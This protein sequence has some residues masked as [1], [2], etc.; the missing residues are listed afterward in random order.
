MGLADLRAKGV[1][2]PR[3]FW[4]PAFASGQTRALGAE[5]SRHVDV[6]RLKAGEPV[7]LFDGKGR[8]AVGSLVPCDGEWSVRVEEVRPVGMETASIVLL[9]GVPKSPKLEQLVRM[10]SEV[11]VAAIHLM[12]TERSVIRPR[13]DR[14]PRQLERLGKIASEAA[15]QSERSTVPRIYPPAPMSEVLERAPAESL[16]LVCV[17]G[18]PPLGHVQSGRPVWV[19]VGPE[20]GLSNQ[21]LRTMSAMEYHPVGLVGHVLRVETA[22]TV[23]VA[24]IAQGL[25]VAR[26]AGG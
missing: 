21:E 9:L 19:V 13:G 23:A 3:R 16:R 24:L 10:T 18:A 17:P 15:R 5:A 4:V 8:E 12:M 26:E 6:L 25:R 1:S 20:G 7:V 14:V 2:A 22:A 11:G